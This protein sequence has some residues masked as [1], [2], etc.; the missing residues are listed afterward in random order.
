M[1][2]KF[3]PPIYLNNIHPWNPFNNTFEAMTKNFE[4]N[5]IP[6][7][8]GNMCTHPVPLQPDL[9]VHHA[10]QELYCVHSSTYPRNTVHSSTCIINKK[11]IHVNFSR[12]YF[13]FRFD[14]SSGFNF[15]WVWVEIICFYRKET[16]VYV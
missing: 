14:F 11:A 7:Y 9:P 1:I 10:S 15:L 16:E 4:W 2:F 3:L 6:A 8:N 5:N 13:F 12:T